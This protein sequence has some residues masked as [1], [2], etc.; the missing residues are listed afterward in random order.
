MK[1]KTLKVG[2]IGGKSNNARQLLKTL[3][4][5]R[6]DTSFKSSLRQVER[7][8]HIFKGKPVQPFPKSIAKYFLRKYYLFET[9]I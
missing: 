7:N 2:H 6:K 5:I 4:N 1:E 3:E 8:A 9:H